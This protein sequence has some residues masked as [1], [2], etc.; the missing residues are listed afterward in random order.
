MNNSRNNLFAAYKAVSCI[1]GEKRLHYS[2]VG[3]S[4]V[5]LCFSSRPRVQVGLVTNDTPAAVS[6]QDLDNFVITSIECTFQIFNVGFS[7]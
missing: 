3:H 1:G 5:L 4:S 6:Q 2:G 7:G